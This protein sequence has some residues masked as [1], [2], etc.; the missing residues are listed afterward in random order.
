MI[1]LVLVLMLLSA[2]GA[3]AKDASWFVEGGAACA[4]DHGDGVWYQAAFDHE[5]DTCSPSFAVGYRNGDWSFGAAY[6]VE[7]RSGPNRALTNDADYD[8]HNKKCRANCEQTGLFETKG[9]VY[10]LF[11]R[12]EWVMA[13]GVTFELGA[14]AYVPEHTVRISEFYSRDAH[15]KV[16]G[17]VEATY[18]NQFEVGG[19]LSAGIGAR[20]DDWRLMARWYPWVKSSGDDGFRSRASL[21]SGHVVT[22]TVSMDF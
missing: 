6:L 3:S 17:P 2:S 18:K 10:G 19:S 11:A 20:I 14:L 8:I 1:R 12:R 22:V 9:R 5:V 15:G 21:Y 16:Y 4:R 7:T 13:R